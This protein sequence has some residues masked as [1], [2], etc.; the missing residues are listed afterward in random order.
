MVNNILSNLDLR[1]ESKFGQY[2]SQYT[3]D[4]LLDVLKLVKDDSD[5]KKSVKKILRIKCSTRNKKMDP[6]GVSL[7]QDLCDKSKFRQY[8][9]KYELDDLLKMYNLVKDSPHEKEAIECILKIKTY[10]NNK[11]VAIERPD[12]N[13]ILYDFW[14][15]KDGYIMFLRECNVN[16]DE[17]EYEFL[18]SLN[19]AINTILVGEEDSLQE[20]T[21]DLMFTAYNIN[22]QDRELL[23]SLKREIDVLLWNWD[24]K[25]PESTKKKENYKWK[26]EDEN[27][28]L[29]D[30]ERFEWKNSSHWFY[31]CNDA[32]ENVAS[33][34]GVM[35][36][37][38]DN[39]IPH[40]YFACDPLFLKAINENSHAMLEMMYKSLFLEWSGVDKDNALL[41]IKSKLKG[42]YYEYIRYLKIR[43]L[44]VKI[45]DIMKM[46]DEWD[47]FEVVKSTYNDR[48]IF[49]DGRMYNSYVDIRS[50]KTWNVYTALSL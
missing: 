49:G 31:I 34:R 8:A 3:V 4:E 37:V 45:V 23:R 30:D 11:N 42:D 12:L 10:K 17:L 44:S 21:I 29:W 26:I 36:N 33:W 48:G 35:Y 7:P 22:I 38:W 14:D 25:E 13:S 9:F 39:F 1:D 20:S 6:E 24:I 32:P 15:N 19:E 5:K 47:R 41:Q 2:A 16:E 50:R 40:H 28:N 43:L 18:K 46:Y 27:D